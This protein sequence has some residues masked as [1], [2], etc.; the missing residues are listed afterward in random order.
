M[1]CL[2]TKARVENGQNSGER[3]EGHHADAENNKQEVEIPAGLGVIGEDAHVQQRRED[4]RDD[5][6]GEA[7]E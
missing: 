7:A 1:T 4:E 2:L 3:G 6:D 5:G